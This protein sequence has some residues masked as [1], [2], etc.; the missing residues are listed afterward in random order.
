MAQQGWSV[1]PDRE[2]VD[3]GVSGTTLDRPVL[4]RL[5]D[6]IVAGQI[7]RVVILSADRSSQPSVGCSSSWNTGHTW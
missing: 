6:A 2:F 4:D 5:R 1:D 3:N 7:Q